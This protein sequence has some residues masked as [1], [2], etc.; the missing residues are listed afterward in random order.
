[1]V[2]TE[3]EPMWR[4]LKFLFTGSWHEHEWETLKDVGLNGEFGA[5]GRRYTCRCK[6][7]GKYKK[8]DL[9]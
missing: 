6:H 1:M 8:F 5:K 7:C 3:N 9:I 4:I 2:E